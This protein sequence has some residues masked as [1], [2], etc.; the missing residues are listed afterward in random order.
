[1]DP[2]TNPDEQTLRDLLASARTIA[3]VGL[4]DS[5]YRPSYG[6]A[7]YLQSQGYRII[8]VNPAIDEALG[9]RAYPDLLSIPD[10]IDIVDIFR[11]SEHV[12][13]HV[14]EAIERGDVRL[15]WMQVGVWNSTAARRAREAGID[16]V[17]SR[18]IMVDHRMLM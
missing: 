6:I 9:E 14:D 8:P 4:S 1:M 7:R 15:I 17:M 16:V 12:G 13:P 2:W 10:A 3:I 5:P 18:C 11:R